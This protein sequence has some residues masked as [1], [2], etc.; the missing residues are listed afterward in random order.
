ML[1]EDTPGKLPTLRELARHFAVVTVFNIGVAIFITLVIDHKY[2]FFNHLVFALAIGTLGWILVDAGRYMIW[3][4]RKPPASKFFLMLMLAAPVAYYGG[5][6]IGLLV[7]SMPISELVPKSAMEMIPEFAF[8][9]STFSVAGWMFLSRAEM[10]DLRA[11]AAARAVHTAAMEKQ[12]MQAQLQLLQTQIEPHMLFNTLANLQ[13][14]IAID[15]KRAQNM[16]DHLIQYLR[17]T[18]A[19]SRAQATT[20]AQEFSLLEAYLGL[21]QVRMGARLSYALHLP[22]ELRTQPIPP[23]LLQPLIENAIKHGL[24]PKVDGGRIDVKAERKDAK[25]FLTVADTGLGM[26]ENGISLHSQPG[27]QIG[28]AN[29]RERLQ[30][31][32]G[33]AACFTLAPNAPT[34]VIAQLTLPTES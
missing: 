21:M 23:M 22:D 30:V 32:Y 8:L 12:A 19:S 25:L 7:L 2:R 29:V 3:G 13:G 10:A 34:G 6:V 5:G 31:L 33:E 11:E 4:R 1:P 18:L 9:I 14:L 24:E 27:T 26:D 16:L 20:L 15:P 17:A 28:T